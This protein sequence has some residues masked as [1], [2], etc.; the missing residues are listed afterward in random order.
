[1]ESTTSR[2]RALNG[3]R[4]PFLQ[5][6]ELSEGPPDRLSPLKSTGF[7][8]KKGT[9][10]S[11]VIQSIYSNE[12]TW[13]KPKDSKIYFEVPNTFLTRL[14]T[15]DSGS[16]QNKNISIAKI[17]NN[18]CSSNDTAVFKSKVI[19]LTMLSSI[20]P[21]LSNEHLFYSFIF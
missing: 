7:C 12:V 19:V 18:K 10:T 13:L 20:F 9:Q 15:P 14:I 5:D 8:H 6:F 17:E 16:Q 11:Q 2:L 21:R 3:G 1:M 4:I